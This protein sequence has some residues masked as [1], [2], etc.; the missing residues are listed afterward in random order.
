M[1]PF[2]LSK[3]NPPSVFNRYQH[4]FGHTRGAS[5]ITLTDP[6][7][8]LVAVAPEQNPAVISPPVKFSR[9]YRLTQPKSI[10]YS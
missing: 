1:Q 6:I 10:R 4:P 2:R 8:R 5:E 7:Y 3:T 9:V